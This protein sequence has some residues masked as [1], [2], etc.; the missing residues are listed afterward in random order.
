MIW[1]NI[2]VATAQVLNFYSESENNKRVNVFIPNLNF[3]RAATLSSIV[4]A[5]NI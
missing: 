2:F 1:I 4:I 3:F 5:L